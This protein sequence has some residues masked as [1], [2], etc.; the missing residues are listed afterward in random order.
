[1]LYAYLLGLLC[2]SWFDIQGRIRKS[3]IDREQRERGEN[4]EK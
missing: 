3:R 1:M 2:R 4:D